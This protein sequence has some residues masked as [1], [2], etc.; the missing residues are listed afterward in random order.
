[1]PPIRMTGFEDDGPPKPKEDLLVAFQQQQAARQKQAV[2][3]TAAK[4]WR[5]MRTLGRA[6]LMNAQSGHSYGAS[7][8]CE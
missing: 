7:A 6:G 1:M 3:D 5:S 2:R 4:S 8:T